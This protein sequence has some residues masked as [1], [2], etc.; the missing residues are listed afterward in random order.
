MDVDIPF[1]RPCHQQGD[2]SCGLAG[3][4]DVV[5]H[6]TYSVNDYQ[7]DIFGSVDCLPHDCYALFG[8]VFP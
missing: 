5:H 3:T 7:P 1:T 2:N 8:R 6:V 4:V